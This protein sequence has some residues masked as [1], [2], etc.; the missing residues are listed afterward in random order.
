MPTSSVS[1]TTIAPPAA[2]RSHGFWMRPAKS[3]SV[4]C[5]VTQKRM[6]MSEHTAASAATRSSSS[7]GAAVSANVKCVGAMPKAFEIASAASDA[8]MHGT[9]AE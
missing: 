7:R 8:T 3:R 1:T 6:L 4:P 9:S 5:M 2:M